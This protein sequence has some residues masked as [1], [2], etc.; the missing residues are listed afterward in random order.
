MQ[1]GDLGNIMMT[2]VAKA[3]GIS[4][5][6]AD[7]LNESCFEHIS[8]EGKIEKTIHCLNKVAKTNEERFYI[9]M[10]FGRIVQTDA[11]MHE[12]IDK[13]MKHNWCG[14]SKAKDKL[15]EHPEF[16]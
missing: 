2:D 8:K 15:S 16:G 6:R 7:V 1:R 5:K 9:G 11:I 10:V 12:G 13:F 3:L 4:Q 14:F